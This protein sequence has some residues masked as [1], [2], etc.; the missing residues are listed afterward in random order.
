[1]QLLVI[2]MIKLGTPTDRIHLSLSDEYQSYFICNL[3]FNCPFPKLTQSNKLKVDFFIAKCSK[4]TIQISDISMCFLMFPNNL[5]FTKNSNPHI[6]LNKNINTI[7]NNITKNTLNIPFDGANPVICA[8]SMK[9]S[10]DKNVSD[11]DPIVSTGTNESV[12]V[13]GKLRLKDNQAVTSCK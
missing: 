13:L 7:G 8:S 1:M 11:A 10:K 5:L 2:Q 3:I 4:N 9:Q 12:I 6:M